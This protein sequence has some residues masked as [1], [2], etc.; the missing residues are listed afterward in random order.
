MSTPANLFDELAFH[1][2]PDVEYKGA[3][4]GLPRDLWET[5]SAFANTD[6]GTLWL[7]IS[8]RNGQLD[9]H[10][11]PAA[12]K[13]VTDFWNTVNNRGKTSINL[14]RNQDVEILHA[15]NP[16]R[17][18][19]RIRVPRADHHQRPVFIG[20]DPLR[21]TYRRNHEGDY[22][23]TESEVR[24]MFADQSDEPA[25]SRVLDHFS[26][27]DLHLDSLRQFRNR[28][29]SRGSHPWLAEDDVG[30]L[31]KL[32]GW[33]KDRRSGREG[34]TL[35]G[36][37]MFGREQ[38]IRD[39][40]AAPGFQL[41]Y[42]EHFDENPDVRWTDRLTL[43]GHWEGNLFQFHHLVRQK[44]SIGPGIK[45]PFER[46]AE[47]YRAGESPIIEALE[48]A[49]VNA[50]IH[51]DYAGQGGIVINRWPDRLEFSN[52]GTLL[53]SREQILKGG[54][55]ECRNKSLQLM[56]QMLGA[57]DK[58][59]SGIDKIRS[60]WSA[61][62]WQ[63]PVLRESHQPDRVVLS[64]P[65][66]SLLPEEVLAWLHQRFGAAFD[67]LSGD[68]IQALVTAHTEGA[69]TNQQLQGMLAMHRVDI[70]RMLGGLVV[71]GF[72]VS[73]GIGRGTRY[74]LPQ[75]ASLEKAPPLGEG[76]PPLGAGAPPPSSPSP[77]RPADDPRWAIAAPV[78]A[79][80][81]VK[82]QVMQ[83]A[84]LA[85]CAED[86]LTLQQLA[87]LLKRGPKGLQE[88]HLAPLT[89]AGRLQLRF[90]NSPN[91]PQQAYRATPRK[92]T[93]P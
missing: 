64:L 52:P 62:H 10:G 88:N 56:F 37:L 44:L 73:D 90:P 14:L 85:L 12:E 91:H 87:A 6:G 77:A 22:Q 1:E 13:L 41:D 36:L 25:D 43:D 46:D 61:Q 75:L 45:R 93:T 16:K 49:L 20:P 35:A 78:R 19:I 42:R 63:S 58:A 72:L 83:A 23:C 60:S 5:Y 32:G 55:S 30:L 86:Y 21:G 89:R 7:G 54:V 68:E 40:S 76:T 57:G 53:I 28:F 15:G 26:L 2:G 71:R 17:A 48:E 4:G 38:A 69:V 47:G 66:L 80:K 67:A 24:R 29:A 9:F 39:P 51:A 82:P 81:K 92:E 84:L 3:R 8:Q 74:S 79:K 18:L 34:L 70:T 59:G 50:L 31:S 33:R 27:D 65:M 11:V